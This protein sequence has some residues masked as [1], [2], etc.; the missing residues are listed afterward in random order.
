MIEQSEYR[1]NKIGR[2]WC[3]LAVAGLI[4]NDQG[5]RKMQPIRDFRFNL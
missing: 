4:G 2:K 3:C 5:C 1:Q